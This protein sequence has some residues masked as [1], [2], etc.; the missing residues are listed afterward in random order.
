MA[1]VLNLE[2][3]TPTGLALKTDA[4]SVAAP[5]V[6]GEFGVLP[7]HLPLLAAL[8]CG[9]LEYVANGK[10]HVA[11][12]GPGFVEA[13]PDK[14]LLLTDMIATPEDIDLSVVK[15]EYTAANEALRAFGER[16]EGPE[17]A[18]LERDK[19]WAE[20]R[21]KAHEMASAR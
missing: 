4:T 5:S 6:R 12:I 14:V 17:F 19:E 1:A 9:V 13:G 18:E 10:K 16:H 15:A 2:V 7:G 11:A 21:I 20:A 3:A 8:R